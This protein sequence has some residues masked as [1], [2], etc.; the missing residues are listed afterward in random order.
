MTECNTIK[1]LF[2]Q[3]ANMMKLPTCDPNLLLS[4]NLPVPTLSSVDEKRLTCE[5]HPNMHF[6]M[7]TDYDNWLDS[8]E[9]AGSNHGLYVYLKDENGDVPKFARLYEQDGEN[10]ASMTEK[11]FPLFKLADNRWKL[12][13][14]CTKKYSA[15]RKHHLDD[16]GN[17]KRTTCNVIKEEGLDDNDDLEDCKPC[18]KKQKGPPDTTR[19]SIKKQKVDDIALAPQLKATTPIH[20]CLPTSSLSSSSVPLPTSLDAVPNVEPTMPELPAEAEGANRGATERL[21]DS[22]DYGKY[23]NASA[24]YGTQPPDRLIETVTLTMPLAETTMAQ[25]K[26]QEVGL[27]LAEKSNACVANSTDISSTTASIPYNP[28]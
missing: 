15:W 5:T 11:E 21:P 26:S 4:S 24:A 10:L 25:Y 20:E 8:P 17:L 14:I 2:D 3:L 23:S 13:Y 1:N 18:G 16:D 7:K 19:P 6:W 27:T 28:M 22:E 9:A 12:K